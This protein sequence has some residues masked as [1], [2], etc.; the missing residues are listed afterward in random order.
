MEF[1]ILQMGFMDISTKFDIKNCYKKW[2]LL[3]DATPINGGLVFPVEQY[4]DV[5]VNIYNKLHIFFRASL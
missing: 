5:L 1:H 2:R 3:F 4:G